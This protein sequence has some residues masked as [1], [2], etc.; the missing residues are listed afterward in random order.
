MGPSGR[1]SGP[2]PLSKSA[3]SRVVGTLK[4][5]LEAWRTR[6]L[7]ELDILG[8]YLD[9]LALWVRSAGRS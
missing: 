1:C 4:A 8:M 7:A 5:E 2:R 6:S 3:V 9:A